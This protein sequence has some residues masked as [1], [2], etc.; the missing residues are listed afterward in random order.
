MSGHDGGVTRKLVATK[1]SPDFRA[2]TAIVE[3]VSRTASLAPGQVL[4]RRA[5][6]GVNASDINFTSGCGALRSRSVE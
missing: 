3:G 4:I 1:L 5:L 2:A 6:T